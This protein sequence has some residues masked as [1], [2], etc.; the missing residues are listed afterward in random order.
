VGSKL[1][2]KLDCQSAQHLV[3]SACVSAGRRANFVL[4]VVL[5]TP[6]VVQPEPGKVYVSYMLHGGQKCDVVCVYPSDLLIRSDG[7][8]VLKE[9]K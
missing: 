3:S 5:T 9:V 6:N 1:F 4:Y 7:Y 8:S 2:L